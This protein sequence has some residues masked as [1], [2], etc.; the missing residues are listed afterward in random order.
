MVKTID[1][2]VRE[3]LLMGTFFPAKGSLRDQRIVRDITRKVGLTQEEKDEI[4]FVQ[5]KEQIRW[6]SEKAKVLAVE[7]NDDEREFFK[8]QISRLDE[9]EGFT[10]DLLALAERLKEL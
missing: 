3:R 4:A 2:T 8:R 1:L 6:N 5:D 10:Q 7:M 9:E